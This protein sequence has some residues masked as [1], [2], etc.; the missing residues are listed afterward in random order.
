ML[1]CLL[2][3]LSNFFLFIGPYYELPFYAFF[4]CW[5]FTHFFKI[6][7][8]R[9]L[10]IY[11]IVYYYCVFQVYLVFNIVMFFIFFL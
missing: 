10:Y 7:F 4:F 11:K 5:G 8:V 3:M 9:A 6:I 1:F 2:I